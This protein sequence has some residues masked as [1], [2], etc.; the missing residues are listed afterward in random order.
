MALTGQVKFPG[1]YTLRT[2]TERLARPDRARRRPD[3]P[4]PTPAA[5][6]SIGRTSDG[7]PSRHRPARVARAG[8]PKRIP[9][10]TIPSP[11]C[12]G[13]DR[14]RPAASAQGSQVPGQPDPRRGRLGS[15]S[16]V[17]PDRD[18]AGRGQLP[19]RGRLYAGEE[20]G[21]VRGCRRRLYP[22]GRTRPPLR[23]P[24]EREAR[25]SEAEGGAV[26]PRA[27]ARSGGGGLRS[28]QDRRA[29]SRATCPAS[30]PPRL[31][32]SSHSPRCVILATQR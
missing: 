24:A 20:S 17:R 16:R 23:D 26:G 10:A 19:G 14:D 21:L 29:S 8:H 31:R 15:H 32:S 1:R 18:G 13:A 5:S 3:R 2:K 30:W 28:D 22:D 27:Q 4:R 9:R 25:G 12:T 7:Q 11:G 6:S